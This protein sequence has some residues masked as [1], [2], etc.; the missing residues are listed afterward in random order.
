MSIN[1][2]A[3]CDHVAHGRLADVQEMLESGEV[4]FEGNEFIALV[5]AVKNGHVDVVDNGPPAEK[6][7]FL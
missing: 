1:F 3:F 5:S 4:R 6:L 7:M 2:D